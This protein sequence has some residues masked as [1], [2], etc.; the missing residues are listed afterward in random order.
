MEPYYVARRSADC[1]REQD[2]LTGRFTRDRQQRRHAEGGP[3]GDG[4]DVH[5]AAD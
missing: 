3:S 2:W 5:P 1:H 4:V